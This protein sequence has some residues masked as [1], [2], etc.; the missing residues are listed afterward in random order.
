MD[1]GKYTGAIYIDLCKAFDTI[2]HAT[3]LNKLPEFGITG[4]P[5]EW[6]SSY[7]FCRYQKVVMHNVVSIPEPIF[8][9][10]PQGSILGPLLFLL[11]FNNS[12]NVLV[13]CNIVKYADDTVLFI[14]HQSVGEIEKLLNEDFHNVCQWLE[15]NELI[16]N[17]KKGKTEFMVFGTNKRLSYL[18]D[19]PIKIQYNKTTINFTTSYKYL[20]LYINNTLNMSEH[21]NMTLKKASTR[22]HILR[23]I[24]YFID[25]HTATIIYE[26]MIIP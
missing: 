19:P 3:I 8:C 23:K 7:L 4:T 26:S 5:Y 1:D 12:A 21:V 2:S 14:T 25:P 20:G 17:L 9:G 22:V 11:H 13:H 15:E 24:R 6:F 18:N 10:V 16:I